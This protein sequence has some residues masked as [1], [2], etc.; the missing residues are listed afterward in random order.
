MQF[1]I[2]PTAH[3][4]TSA[5]FHLPGSGRMLQTLS[6][7][8]LGAPPLSGSFGLPCFFY[9]G[10]GASSS[11]FMGSICRNSRAWLCGG[12]SIHHPGRGHFN[13]HSGLVTNSLDNFE[14]P[15]Q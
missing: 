4:E 6:S 2:I 15:H 13:F 5:G 9:N 11:G 12:Q 1:F 8:E 10:F 14:L 3:G 7:A